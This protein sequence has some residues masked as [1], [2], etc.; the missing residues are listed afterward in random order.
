[1]A[2]TTATNFTG[3]LQ[4]PIAT[5]ATDI[6]KKEDLQTL[7]QAVDQHDHTAGKGLS[8]APANASITNAKLASDTARANLLTNGGFEIWQRGNGPFSAS[9][10][11]TDRWAINST[12]G[13]TWSVVRDTANIDAA[14]LACAACTIS[15]F[16]SEVHLSQRTEDVTQ[17]RGRVVSFSVRVRT[18]TA[19]AVRAS[20]GQDSGLTYGTYHTGNGAYQTL[21]VTAT[22][23]ANATIVSPNVTFN[24]N[25]TAYIDNA[26]LVV[27]SVPADYAPLHPADDLARCLR[28]YERLDIPANGVALMAQAYSTTQ[29]MWLWTFKTPKAITPT[30]TFSAANQFGTLNSAANPVTGTAI[31]T[32]TASTDR[33][34]GPLTVAS[35]LIAGNASILGATTTGTAYMISEGNP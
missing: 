9:V 15:A 19:N 24:A 18:T 26:M 34:N 25:C 29:V 12:A 7:A 11:T 22:V 20:I 1:V 5:A 2:R 30:L 8:V 27:G 13:A 14:S 3:P 31:S 28:Y 21:T 17:L 4:Y 10:F 33:A 32:F 6:F 23:A 35:G 16:A